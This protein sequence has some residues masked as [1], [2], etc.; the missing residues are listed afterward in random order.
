MR[1]TVSWLLSL[2]SS[3]TLLYAHVASAKST[4]LSAKGYECIAFTSCATG[5]NML[6]QN[7]TTFSAS[8]VQAYWAHLD[9]VVKKN[10]VSEHEAT[11]EA[12]AE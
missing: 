12:V 8:H 7:Q 3:P 9:H 2:G 10:E 11:P 4:V 1:L 6:V 5:R